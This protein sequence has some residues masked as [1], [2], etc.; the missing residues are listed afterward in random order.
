MVV[1][2]V[3]SQKIRRLHEK[4]HVEDSIRKMLFSSC[5]KTLNYCENN[6]GSTVLNLFYADIE[7]YN[8][9]H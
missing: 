2:P 8:A 1:F 6:K 3:H 5:Q 9:S 4:E 7:K